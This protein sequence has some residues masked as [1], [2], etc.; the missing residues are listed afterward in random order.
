M[1]MINIISIHYS[2]V[3]IVIILTYGNF[4]SKRMKIIFELAL[5]TFPT[6]L[7]DSNLKI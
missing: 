5:E 6:T 7:D 4:E 1:V 2:C 3:E